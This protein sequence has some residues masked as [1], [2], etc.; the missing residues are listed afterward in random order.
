MSH[1]TKNDELASKVSQSG[2][3]YDGDCAQAAET[4]YYKDHV[5]DSRPGT[6]SNKNQSTVQPF[7]SLR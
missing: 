7:K 6:G 3:H 4:G 1:R 5:L 2:P